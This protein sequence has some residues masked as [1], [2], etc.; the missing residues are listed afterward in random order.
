MAEQATQPPGDV[1][2]NS[3]LGTRNPKLGTF[4]PFVPSCLNAF[5]PFPLPSHSLLVMQ[6]TQGMGGLPGVP[7]G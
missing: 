7:D 4:P 1:R 2:L 6:T 5:V 3:E